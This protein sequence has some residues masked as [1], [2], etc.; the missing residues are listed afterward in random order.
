MARGQRGLE[1]SGGEESG[2]SEGGEERGKRGVGRWGAG[3]E[4]CEVQEVLVCGAESWRQLLS[5]LGVEAEPGASFTV[6]W[7]HKERGG[8][9]RG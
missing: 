5:C 6:T 2:R 4:V 3:R 8:E 1:S 7:L 9:V